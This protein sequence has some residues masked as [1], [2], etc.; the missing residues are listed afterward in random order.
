MLFTKFHG[1]VLGGTEQIEYLS[2]CISNTLL[3]G[4]VIYV[5]I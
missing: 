2:C 1:E 4:V 3:V 5:L